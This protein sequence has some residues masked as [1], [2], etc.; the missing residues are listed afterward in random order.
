MLQLGVDGFIIQPTIDFKVNLPLIVDSGKPIV[1][2]DSK[3]DLENAMTVMADNYQAVTEAMETLVK[4]NYD[5]Y[6]LITADS[7]IISTRKERVDAFKE[8]LNKHGLES[9]TL[10]IK[11]NTSE[12]ELKKYFDQQLDLQQT[13]LIFVPNC[14]F[15]AK[16]FKS[17]K[18]KKNYIPDQLAILG[19]DNLEWTGL[20]SPSVTTIVQPAFEEGQEAA[21]ILIDKIENKNEVKT[22]KVLKCRINYLES[23]K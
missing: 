11:Q 10:N 3:I 6:F 1:Y 5:N 7:S 12:I 9:T 17:L 2:L 21:L 13:N 23:T 18:D 8:V 22:N 16:V 15:L 14:W 19:Y 4:N 20:S